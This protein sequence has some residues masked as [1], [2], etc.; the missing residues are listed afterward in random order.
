MNLCCNMPQ[1]SFMC[2]LALI[3]VWY[4]CWSN[5]L[6]AYNNFVV[7]HCFM[8]GFG[9]LLSSSVHAGLCFLTVGHRLLVSHVWFLLHVQ[10]CLMALYHF[11]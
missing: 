8:A 7:S 2:F 11:L 1:L 6:A 3:P 4:V 10:H 5:H 9:C